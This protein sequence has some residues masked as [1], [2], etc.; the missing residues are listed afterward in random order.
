MLNNEARE[1]LEKEDLTGK[2]WPVD[3]N[4]VLNIIICKAHSQTHRNI[5]YAMIILTIFMCTACLL[6]FMFLKSPN[7]VSENN[8]MLQ[9]YEPWY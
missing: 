5:K 8:K 7:Y 2:I 1:V 9:V 4:K 3:L 6:I